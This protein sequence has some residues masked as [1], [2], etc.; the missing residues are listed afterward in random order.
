MQYLGTISK[1]KKKQNNLSLIPKQTIQHHSNSNLCPN[2]W[3]WRS[4]SWLAPWRPTTLARTSH[5]KR[6][7]LTYKGL[8]CKSRKSRDTENNGEIWPWNTK[9]SRPEFNSSVKKTSWLPQ[10]P[11]SNNQRDARL[12]VEITRWLI[13]KSDW[14]SSLFHLVWLFCWLWCLFHF[15]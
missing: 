11:F 15:F 1:K 6:C 12:N 9:L 10:T 4:W 2:H 14:L 5:K 7:L 8:E 3:C 13:W